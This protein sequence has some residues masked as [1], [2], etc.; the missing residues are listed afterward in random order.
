MRQRLLWLMVLLLPLTLCL[1]AQAQ[2]N[3][4]G[5]VRTETGDVVSGASVTAE[6]SSTKSKTTVTTNEEGV[7]TFSGLANGRYIFTVTFV[8]YATE[9]VTGTVGSDGL[10]LDI[11]LKIAA[12]SLEDV[13][14]VGYGTQR[15][16][17]VT[18]AVKSVKAESFNRGIV[19]NPQQLLQG[20]VAGVNITSSSGEPGAPVNIVIRGAASVRNGSAPLFVV[21]GVPLDNAGTGTGDPLNFLNP[22]DIASMDVLKDASA[23]AIYGSRGANGVII[24][25]TKR[26]RAGTSVLNFTTSAGI[27]KVARKLP[28]FS[29]DEFKKQVVAAGGTLEDFGSSTDW[30][31][32]I[33]RTG[34][35]FENNLTLSGG[36]NKL[37]YYAS[38]NAQN[39]TG[40][41][42][43]SNVKRYTGRFNA[44]QKFWDDRLS[45]DVNL[46]ATNTNNRRPPIDGLLGTAISNNPTL[47]ARDADGS[48]AKF[49]NA[50]NP[51][52]DLELYKDVASVNR[53]LGNISPTLR[54]I[55]GLTY[56]LNFGIDNATT[57]RDIVNFANAEPQRD[58]RFETQG[59]LLRNRLIENYLTYTTDIDKHSLSA[60]AGHSYQNILYRYRSSS[61][62]K[63]PL[64][65]LDPTYNPGIGQELTMANN[66]P[67]GTANISELQSYF[68]R[69]NY[70]FDNRYL[71]T[72]SFRMDGSTKFGENNRY[73]YFPSFSLGWNIKEEAFMANS[74]FSA[75][76]LR[77]GWGMT[78]NQE[79]E[80]KS[81]QAFYLTEVTSSTS[82]PLNPTG[83]Y[84]AGTRFARLANPDLQWESTQQT[85][86]GLEFGLLGGDLSGSVDWFDKITNNI[87]L[88]IPPQDPVQPEGKL[89]ANIPGME[90]RNTGIEFDLEYRKKITTNLSA[91]IGG[92]A[93]FMKNN[94]TGSP[95]QVIFSGSATGSGLT[96]ATLNGYINGNPIGSFYLLDFIG[97]DGDGMSKYADSDKDGIITPKDRIIAGSAVPK[98]LYSFF[99]NLSYKG[100]D[101]IVNFNGVGGNKIYDNTATANFYKAKIAKN[102]NTTTEAIQYPS[103]S[104]NNAA[105]VSTRYLKDGGYLRLNNMMLAYNFNTERLGVKKWITSLRL[106]VTAQNLFVITKYDGFDP[107]IN[108]DRSI[109][110]AVS[111]GIDYL[112]YPKARSVIFGLNLSF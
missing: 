27:S 41:L 15:K 77:G 90:I 26:G 3:V 82:Y 39:Q 98:Y 72:A 76:K 62:N 14:V 95:Y 18:G 107:E 53:V 67:T 54:I 87:L 2:K 34:N 13:V 106:S 46:T 81:T 20:K 83:T 104:I 89:F 57:T 86:I 68:A 31:D 33:F 71:L 99:G 56:K 49:Q 17:D 100:F 6:N 21:D 75:L 97:I 66:R 36:A 25:T 84:P 96:S 12:Q 9:S 88:S 30:Q 101:F 93:T 108:S 45:V 22:Q 112:N 65:D 63:L 110:R 28:V 109:D 105:S 47:P 38:L 1:S 48:P 69:I 11:V 55:K 50:S 94:V 19:N 59:I 111:Y 70:G 64:N 43:G 23:T 7:F 52:L 42:K 73:G 40:I 29:T 44:T 103:E 92:N 91:G 37:V 8:G 74:I 10:Q 61:I 60:M 5:T 35:T 80:P 58:G 102:S 4:T 16:K 85:N 79:I 24:V 51:L 32:E 78:G